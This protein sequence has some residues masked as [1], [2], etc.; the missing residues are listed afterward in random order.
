ML[1]EN[2]IWS[3][4]SPQLKNILQH[5]DSFRYQIIYTRIDRDIKGNPILKIIITGSIQMEYFNPAST[6]KMPLAFLALEKINEL[7]KYGI[8][9]NT[10]HAH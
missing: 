5:P 1:P 2:L 6:V 10:G 9:M 7:K 4:A 3:N 8:N